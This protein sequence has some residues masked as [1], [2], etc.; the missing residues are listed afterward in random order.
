ML[1][2][3]TT[4]YKALKKTAHYSQKYYVIAGIKNHKK[5]SHKFSEIR[6]VIV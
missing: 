5:T 6:N 3:E 2:L 4:T 1:L